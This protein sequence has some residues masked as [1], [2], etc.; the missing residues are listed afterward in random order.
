MNFL[1]SQNLST[2]ATEGD[3]KYLASE[4]MQGIF[5]KYADIFSLGMTILELA[6]DLDLPSRGESWHV[7]RSGRI[8]DAV[9]NGITQDLKHVITLMLNPD[10]SL[11]P[12]ARQL[13]EMPKVACKE[14][15]RRHHLTVK[16]YLVT[17]NSWFSWVGQIIQCYLLAPFVGLMRHFQWTKTIPLPSTPQN[18]KSVFS[19]GISPLSTPE[20]DYSRANLSQYSDDEDD[21]DSR[22]EMK[23]INGGCISDLVL[24]EDEALL[25][26]TR[27]YILILIAQM[28]H[29]LV[30]FA[31]P[32]CVPQ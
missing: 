9:F 1:F 12:S 4:L 10:Y 11:R 20:H 26:F 21:F 31:V 5:T 15:H 8:P 6:S 25:S 16:K 14:K 17:A 23:P 19:G 18:R 22:F 24:P 13:L 27:R 7:L 29:F 30:T 32:T 2:E 28:F 3:P